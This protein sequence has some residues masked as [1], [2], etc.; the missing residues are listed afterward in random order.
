MTTSTTRSAANLAL[1]GI[2]M[3]RQADPDRP[4]ICMA[5]D[6][7]VDRIRGLCVDYGARFHNTGYMAAFWADYLPMLMRGVDLPFS[8]EPGGA[9]KDLPEFKNMLG[10]WLTEGVNAI[11]YFI[12]VG[13]VLWNDDIRNHFQEMLPVIQTTGKIHVPKSQVAPL[14]SDRVNNLTGYPWGKDPNTNL[15]SGY[16]SW[17]INEELRDEYRCDGL[18][19][20]DFSTGSAAAYPVIIDT[21]TSIMDDTLVARIEEWV[22]AGGTFI[23]YVQTGRHTPER[24]NA[25]PICRLTGYRVS[26]I[27][28]IEPDGKA[29]QWRPLKIAPGQTI[30]DAAGWNANESERQRHD[31]GEG[32][33]G[34]PGPDACARRRR[35]GRRS[36]VGQG[37]HRSTRRQVQQQQQLVGQ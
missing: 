9:A 24:E 17:R 22:K 1:R 31:A 32:R 2:E 5:P 35:G 18:T 20:A 4:I 27:D 11:H 37:R 25:W 30:L 36:P 21:N 6:S 23:T 34:V 16:W 13:D 3:I 10:L 15:N 33:A 29:K 12:H 7:Y 14:Y 26:G 8:L 28:P 19:T